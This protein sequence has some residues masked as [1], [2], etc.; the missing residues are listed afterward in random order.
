[1]E[2]LA[3]CTICPRE[4]GVNRTQGQTG[5]C[6]QTSSFSLA[7]AALHLWEEP[8]ISGACGSGA[9]FFSGCNMQCVFCQNHPIA[10]SN[11]GREVSPSRLVEIY[12]ELQEKG[13]ANI[14]L[15][16]PTHFLP[17]IIPT[18]E[19]AK[20][21]G[22]KIPIVYNTSG[23][24]KV[25]SLRELEG[26]ID[27]YLPD[28]KYF[29][30]QLS[31]RL[32]SAP[33]YFEK[34]SKA[35]D[36]MYRQV[37]KPEMD[38]DTGLMKRGMIVRH[39]C[40]PGQAKDTKKVLRYLRNTFGSNI[41]IS[42]MNQYT[43]MPQLAALPGMEDLSRSLTQEEYGKILKFAE[44]IGIEQGFFQEGDTQSQSFIPAFTFE[45]L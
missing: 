24:E 13:A 31:H 27:I 26:L 14:N 33:D 30:P 42:I 18:L 1:M 10:I 20:N 4:C 45:G 36:E 41:Y 16:T 38:Y 21:L 9:V 44:A 11:H 32:S 6:R 22:L 25:E 23:Y 5:F 7:R 29:S 19:K 40:L 3:H 34:T 12:L 28:C 15:V 8:C 37:G 39:L 43:P 35:L 2:K 17:Q